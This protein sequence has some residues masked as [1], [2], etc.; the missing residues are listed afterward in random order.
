MD[1]TR[2]QFLAETE[3]LI[4]QIFVDLDELREKEGE[5]RLQREVVE[6]IF[7]SVHRVKGSAAS[8]GLDGLSEIAH[9]FETLLSAVRAG[10]TGIDDVVIDA[11]EIATNTLAESLTMAASGVV[12]PSRRAL[13]ERIRTLAQ[14][15]TSAPEE[16][17]DSVLNKLPSEIWQSLTDDEKQRL[18]QAVREGCR[19]SVVT[20]S[21][22][23]AS[24]DEEFYRLK[25][26]LTE[27]GEVIS[28]SPTV[29]AQLS[30]RINFRVLFASDD[31]PEDVTG[32]LM[33]FSSVVVTE[34][35]DVRKA[36]GPAGVDAASGLRSASVSALSN[37]VRTDLDD[38][39]R[40]I[41]STHELFRTTGSALTLALGQTKISRKDRKQLETLDT[42]IRRS[43]MEVESELI[44][45][46]M[47]SLGP[48]LQQA[49]RAG[50][51]A[52]RLSNKEIDFEI[53][54][55]D[56]RL[57]KLLVEAIADPLVH[58][59]RNAVDHGIEAFE[60]RR[61]AQKKDRGLV[62]IQA[63]SKGSQTRVR[64][65]DDGRGVDPSRVTRA[66][67]ERGIIG[68]DVVLDMDRSLRLIFRPGFSTSSSVTT[69]SGRGVGLDVVESS[70]ELVGGELRVSSEPGRGSTF[71][72]GLPVTFGLLR[73]I[74]VDSATN[75]YAFDASLVVRTLTIHSAQI[76][77][78]EEGEL[79]KFEDELLSLV[80][81]RVLLGQSP[82]ELVA[83]KIKV[84]ICEFPQS[85]HEGLDGRKRTAIVV[86]NVAGTEEVL[87]RNLGRHAARWPG[88]AGATELRN[89]EVALV[90]DLQRLVSGR[91]R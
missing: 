87:V 33:T 35:A 32:D 20:T 71:E 6:G 36:R 34:V 24:F 44:N 61:Q 47:V 26:K 39:D 81:M 2:R 3:D 83:K 8:F 49:V 42:Q 5:G 69:V 58:L 18:V 37:F 60:E 89:G 63:V 52:A 45:L 57:D 43:F 25:E 48:V 74:L 13:F 66:A 78:I 64:V 59:V 62:R 65:E 10:L 46:R 30:D 29:D 90:L 86:D 51:A 15:N 72:I 54:G 12:E 11:C 73:A 50:K 79:L 40:L 75:N 56:L 28:T 91:S 1:Q 23:I 68:E 9:E 14:G 41:S 53:V 19:L 67:I 7:R 88:I 16:D 82:A 76:E 77:I 22:D 38:L 84:I 55:S 4:E 80:R 85:T 17:I 21:F 31:A 27:R 70:V